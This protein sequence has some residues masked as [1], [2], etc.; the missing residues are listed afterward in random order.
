MATFRH[1]LMIRFEEDVTRE[2]KEERRT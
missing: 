1:L 2:Q